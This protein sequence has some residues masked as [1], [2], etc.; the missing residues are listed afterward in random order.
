LKYVEYLENQI[1]SEEPLTQEVTE[2]NEQLAIRGLLT[3]EKDLKSALCK[4]LTQLF[5]G[6][7]I[8]GLNREGIEYP[9]GGRRIDVL[10]EDTISDTL[11]A[12]ELKSGVAGDRAFGQ[13]A[14][15]LGL[16]KTRFPDRKIEGLIISAEIDESLKHAC[17]IADSVSL[18]TYKMILQLEE[19]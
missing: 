9:I 7:R 16:L 13:I 8:F 5:P 1:D 12:I 18:K 10:L 14:A 2:I 4:Q 15:Y 3:Y 6:Y 19:A 17:L 11:L